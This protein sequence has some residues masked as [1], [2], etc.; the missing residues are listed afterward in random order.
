MTNYNRVFSALVHGHRMGI[1]A[2]S[3]AV[4]YCSRGYCGKLTIL[5]GAAVKWDSGLWYAKEQ[6]VLRMHVGT[7]LCPFLPAENRP[8]R[9]RN[10]SLLQHSLERDYPRV[11]A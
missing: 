6:A 8:V 11:V 9:T 7:F 1:K 10:R 4:T 5:R 2:R 3:R